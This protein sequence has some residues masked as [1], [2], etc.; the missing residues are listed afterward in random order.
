M[1]LGFYLQVTT[2][3]NV[4]A[5]K[6]ILND[7]PFHTTTMDQVK[8]LTVRQ[9]NKLFQIISS[10]KE[11]GRFAPFIPKIQPK[12][13]NPELIKHVI[14][15][16]S[17]LCAVLLQFKSC[18]QIEDIHWNPQQIFDWVANSGNE[19]GVKERCIEHFRHFGVIANADCGNFVARLRERQ[20]K[21][22]TL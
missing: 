5:L 14:F 16:E 18:E 8:R 22:P 1:E 17:L 7:A 3:K 9:M 19:Q 11:A 6:K 21:R 20:R 10:L 4:D 15:D 13:C 2:E 12:H